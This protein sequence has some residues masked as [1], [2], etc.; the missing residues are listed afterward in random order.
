MGNLRTNWH[1]VRILQLAM[2]LI[3]VGSYVFYMQD[4]ITL[5]FGLILLLQAAFNI[6]CATGACRVPQQRHQTA[7]YVR[8][9]EEVEYDEI[10]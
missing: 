7:K 3:L 6:S 8:Q 2:G 5:A 10:V 4:G 9:E 1:I